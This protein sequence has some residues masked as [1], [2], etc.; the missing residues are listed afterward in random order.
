MKIIELLNLI[1]EG[2]APKKILYK[3]SEYKF[4]SEMNDYVNI[5]NINLFAYLFK[6]ESD[7]LEK[8]IEVLEETPNNEKIELINN[9]IKHCERLDKISYIDTNKKDR[10][11]YIPKINWLIDKV[12]YLLDKKD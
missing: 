12:N 3:Y 8:E 6:W 10:E 4:D 2:K 7:V 11:I 1:H 9:R 5:D